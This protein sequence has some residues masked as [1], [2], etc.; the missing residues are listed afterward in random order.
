M[1]SR[2]N[3][4]TCT[5]PK[6]SHIMINNSGAS[7]SSVHKFDTLRNNNDR[8][9]VK[10]TENYRMLD[11]YVPSLEGLIPGKIAIPNSST[12]AEDT[13]RRQE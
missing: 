4:N 12:R 8:L 1:K 9:K 5:R 13:T 11:W 3:Y 2:Q 10:K 7:L 6:T